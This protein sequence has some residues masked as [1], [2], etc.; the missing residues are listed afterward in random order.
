MPTVSKIAVEYQSKG[1]GKVQ[2]DNQRVQRSISKTS[3]KAKKEE[4]T[5]SDWMDKHKK[6]LMAIG[7]ATAGIAAAIVTQAGDM[8]WGLSLIRMEF[9]LLAMTIMQDV[10]PTLESLAD[11]LGDVRK[12]YEDLP[13]PV[14]NVVSHILI[15]SVAITPLIWIGSKV[16]GAIGTAAGAFGSLAGILG[17]SILTLGIIIGIIIAFIA[18]LVIVEE[19][20]GYISDTIS[21]GLIPSVQDLGGWLNDLIDLWGG[22][23]TAIGKAGEAIVD[24]FSNLGSKIADPFTDLKVKMN[25]WGR[26][27][28][29]KMNEGLENIVDWFKNLPSDIKDSL[30]DVFAFTKFLTWGRD[31]AE[32]LINGIISYIHQKGDDIKDALAEYISFDKMANDRMAQTWGKDMMMN[33]TQGA[34]EINL[35]PM[36]GEARNVATSNTSVV[37]ISPGAI[38]IEGGNIDNNRELVEEIADELGRKVASR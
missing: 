31:M 38:R 9:S 32:N 36:T 16:A 34:T 15:F 33:F 1:A 37:N 22:F 12:A 14:S 21:M 10:N 25:E 3:R 26:K 20:T 7:G 23:K 35:S 8:A 24:F 13:D 29:I 19:K 4:S 2:K 17:V 5:I 28:A 18:V 27:L 11:V 30:E 6:G